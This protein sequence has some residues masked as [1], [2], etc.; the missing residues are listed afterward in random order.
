MKRL[1]KAFILLT[2]LAFL[3]K[4]AFALNEKQFSVDYDISY[5]IQENGET[6]IEQTATLTNLKNDVVPTNYTFSIKELKIYDIA[7]ETNGKKVNAETVN[8]ENGSGFSV[9]IENQSIGQ[10]RKNKIFVTFKTADIAVKGGNVWNISIP[11]IQIP[12][13]TE[14]YNVRVYVPKSFG[15][16]MYFS[17]TPVTEKSEDDN[18]IYYLTKDT[19]RGSGVSAAFGSP[20]VFNFKIK[21]QL[22]NRSIFP[23]N[24]EVALPP[25]ITNYQQVSYT[26]INPKPRNFKIDQDGNTI[27]TFLLGSKKKLEVE[28]TG[29]AKAFTP[30]INSDFGG[31]FFTIPKDL[32]SKYTRQQKYW[33]TKS[34]KMVQTAGGL[35]NNALNVVKNADLAYNFVVEN[36][37][38]DF[39]AV[40]KDSV[41]RQGSEVA[42]T[43]KGSWTCMEYTDLFVALARTMGIPAREVDGYAFNLNENSKPLSLNLKTGDLLHSW[44]E[45]YDPNYGWVQVDPTWGSTSGI[46]YFTKLD[47][48]RLTLVIRGLNSEYPLP[49]GA[50][51]FKEGDKLIEVDYSM[52]DSTAHFDPRV[53]LQK[54]FNFNLI[55][56]I[57][58]N[59]RYVAKNEGSV[60]I[61]NL[62]GKTI[63]PGQETVVYIPK[64]TAQIT[65][66]TSDGAPHTLNL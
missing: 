63:L 33:N 14:I 22:E 15:P 39:N 47:T 40:K 43:Q 56:V 17:P 55:E 60:F 41:E 12:D 11:K 48:N 37:T 34:A 1:V 6:L 4:P 57:K 18:T 27:A 38:Y 50:Y 20:Q 29:S 49:A 2:A 66:K 7:A 53:T 42:L 51:K 26:G 59:S 44:A 9:P 24:F 61:Y 3:I 36:L 58:G 35:K 8:D 13:S 21:Y 25:D 52:E 64:K 23:S 46:D 32:I 31:N 16:K 10:G 54:V 5:K 65:F 62:A 19:F 28:V 45:F 30:Q